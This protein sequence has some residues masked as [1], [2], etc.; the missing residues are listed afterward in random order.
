MSKL[1]YLD[2][3]Q[4]DIFDLY[5][6]LTQEEVDRCRW[7]MKITDNKGEVKGS[8]KNLRTIEDI[9]TDY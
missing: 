8:G 5:G 9:F 4:F 3:A 2:V 7:L 6:V 1:A